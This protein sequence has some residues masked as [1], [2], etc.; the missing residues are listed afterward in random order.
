[1]CFEKKVDADRYLKELPGRLAKFNLEFGT[2]RRQECASEIKPVGARN[3]WEVYVIPPSSGFAFR[4]RIQ[5]ALSRRAIL[6]FDFFWKKTRRNPLHR[7]VT[8]KTNPKKFRNSLKSMKEWLK[9]ARSLPLP[10]IIATLKRKLISY[11]NH[12]TIQPRRSSI[13]ASL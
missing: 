13:C 6:G 9:K 12:E 11:I 7:K 5:K 4:L 2:S 1:M 10:D 8:R 3:Q